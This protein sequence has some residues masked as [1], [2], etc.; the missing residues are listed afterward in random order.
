M[1]FKII[2]LVMAALLPLTGLAQETQA[3]TDNSSSTKA[4]QYEEIK[5]FSDEI[6][7]TAARL[8]GRWRLLDKQQKQLL[9]TDGTPVI[10]DKVE[11]VESSPYLMVVSKGK[12]FLLDAQGKP[13]AGAPDFD[14][15]STVDESTPVRYF[16][17]TKEDKEAVF[18]T[19]IGKVT[20]FVYDYLPHSFTQASQRIIFRKDN[21]YGILDG[22]LN[23][24][25]PAT[26]ERVY[27]RETFDW[28]EGRD[29]VNHEQWGVFVYKTAML[30][31]AV[32]RDIYW[33]EKYVFAEKNEGTI[34]VFDLTTGKRIKT[35]D[36]PVAEI[37]VSYPDSRAFL[38]TLKNSKAGIV[39]IDGKVIIPHKYENFFLAD[40]TGDKAFFAKKE[41]YY[42]LIDYQEN[43]HL[44]FEYEDLTW[45][46][47]DGLI[48]A[49]KD[50]KWKFLTIDG[51]ALCDWQN[52]IVTE[53]FSS[54]LGL[55]VVK[56]TDLASQ[57]LVDKSCNIIVP[58]KP[59]DIKKDGEIF[60]TADKNGREIYSKTGKLLSKD[61]YDY[62][63]ENNTLK[64]QSRNGA[65]STIN[66]TE[67]IS[68]EKAKAQ[69]KTNATTTEQ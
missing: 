47:D 67:D 23:E 6:N 2:P 31:P 17:L 38:I 20:D 14:N 55:F 34:D 16:S 22:E 59:H 18:D 33:S 53:R 62:K 10:Y 13:V 7:I 21:R 1:T 58:I 24:L 65:W 46:D 8:L 39:D 52:G 11:Q 3:S 25:L 36:F 30:I 40:T 26:L 12:G 37:Q 43:V 32:Y 15:I 50:L 60:V 27:P 35:T 64:V 51:T 29:K 44:P 56:N 54:D 48:L 63:L 57:G 66:L 45:Y 42:G 49:E 4:P 41:G 5:Q 69:S 9:D 28:L 61:A 68:T 19:Q